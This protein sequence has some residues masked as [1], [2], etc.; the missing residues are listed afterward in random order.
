MEVQARAAISATGA[1]ITAARVRVL[2][3]LLDAASAL[4]HQ[5]L[6][7][8]LAG[9]GPIDRVT[10]YR[11]LDWLVESGLAHRIAGEDRIWRFSVAQPGEAAADADH[12]HAHEPHGHFQCDACRR[13]FCI[14]A[15]TGVEQN[16]ARLPEGFVGRDIEMLVRGTC[17]ACARQTR[18]PTR[19]ATRTPA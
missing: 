6:L 2:S 8:K 3:T 12:H 4:T 14:D 17:P 11:V 10:L 5:D 7:D 1:R 9:N 13:M 19:A 18:R 15:P 16:L